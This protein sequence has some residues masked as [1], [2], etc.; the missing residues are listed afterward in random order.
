MLAL[1][2]QHI[3]KGKIQKLPLKFKLTIETIHIFQNYLICF[4][5]VNS[6]REKYTNGVKYYLYLEGKLD[7][8]EKF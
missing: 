6:F 1:T 7:I 5:S 4:L 8:F 3:F 2:I